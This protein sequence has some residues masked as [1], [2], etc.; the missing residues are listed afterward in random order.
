[1]FLAFNCSVQ[2]AL[3]LQTGTTSLASPLCCYFCYQWVSV[4]VLML[5]LG[6]SC[7]GVLLYYPGACY[8]VFKNKGKSWSRS[9][10][11]Q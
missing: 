4:W 2:K 3:D 9:S 6:V 7:G 1:M 11:D 8:C 10:S 5:R